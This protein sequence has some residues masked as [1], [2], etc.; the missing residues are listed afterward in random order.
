MIVDFL[1]SIHVGY[2]KFVLNIILQR[3]NELTYSFIVNILKA[4]LR[5]RTIPQNKLNAGRCEPNQTEYLRLI[6]HMSNSNP[7]K[8]WME[9]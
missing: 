6:S 1:A 7:H 2:V 4:K 9:T 3:R 5:K 8:T